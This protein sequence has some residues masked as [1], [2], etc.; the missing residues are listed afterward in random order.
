MNNRTTISI[1]KKTKKNLDALGKK[2]E[3]YDALIARL[4]KERDDS[5]A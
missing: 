2:N 3:S 5:Y 4:I 1:H